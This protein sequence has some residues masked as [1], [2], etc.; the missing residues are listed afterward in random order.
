MNDLELP[1]V[2]V[3]CTCYNH[4][5]YVREA[6]DSVISQTYPK[7]ELIIVDNSSTDRSVNVILTFLQE[8]PSINFL[9]NSEN[10]GICKAF[11][12]AV[13]I[14]KGKYLIDLAADD[15][16]LPHR[17][18]RQV[19]LFEKLGEEY[20]IIYSNVELIDSAGKHLEF[21]L[22]N[23]EGPSGHLFAALLEKHFLPSPSTMFRASAFK[24]LGGY[25]TALAFEDFDYWIRCSRGHLFHYDDFVGTKKRVLPRSLSSQ[26]YQTRSNHMLEST[27]VTF[28]WAASRLQTK[29]EHRAFA[30]GASYYFR[31]CVWLG[32]FETA[33]KFEKLLKET[34]F[35]ADVLTRL[36]CLLLRLRLNVSS[37][38]LRYLG[39]KNPS[40]GL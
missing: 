5:S 26:F 23:I 40:R 6:L 19:D 32:H 9:A 11:N 25:N 8:H 36:A 12:E 2:T 21:S 33:M 10:K 39:S 16:L 24:L 3:V 13:Q 28:A 34:T 22:S 31:Q 30:K 35:S 1:W 14:A 37:A 20:G 29:E 7:V 4:E 15:L 17:I 18:Q 38:Y 27:Y